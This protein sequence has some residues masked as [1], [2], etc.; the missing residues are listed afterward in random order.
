MND[1]LY[2]DYQATTP[3]DDSVLEAMLPWFKARFGN[4]SSPHLYGLQAEAAVEKARRGIAQALGVDAAEIVF[5]SGATE[6]NNLLIKGYAGS[7]HGGHV[8]SVVTEHKSVLAPLRSPQ[9]QGFSVTL[10]PVDARGVLDPQRLQDALRDDTVLVSTMYGNNETGS[11]HPIDAIAS[12]A[13]ARGIALHCDATQAIGQIPVQP[14]ALGID[15][16]TFSGH[17]IYGPKGIGVAY[18]NRQLREDRLLQPLIEGGGQEAGLRGGTPNVP[19]IVGLQRAVE[20]AQALL[21]TESQRAAQLRQ[22]FLEELAQRVDFINNTPLEQSLPH[23]VNLS[24]PGV[25]P[26]TLLQSLSG[27]A[28]SDG[29]ACNSGAQQPSHVLT[30]MGLPPA[31]I[32]ASLRF[33][34]GRPTTRDDALLAARLLALDIAACRQR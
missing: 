22:A 32:G 28:V 4:P 14:R 3:M 23:C 1:I 29:S 17:K 21:A 20:L 13:H 27:L 16:M 33:S 8:V 10:L 7:R 15:L 26:Q 9:R 2:L 24:F 25:N 30:A 12:V 5:T 11:L 19:A 31:L 18:V 34:F 6:A